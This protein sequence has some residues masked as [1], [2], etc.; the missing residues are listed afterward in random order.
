MTNRQSDAVPKTVEPAYSSIIALIDKV[1][2][3]QLNDE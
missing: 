3:L 2:H 1:C